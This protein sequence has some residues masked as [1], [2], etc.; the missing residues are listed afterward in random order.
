MNIGDLVWC[1]HDYYHLP[2][3]GIIVKVHSLNI[4]YNCHD[5]HYEIL[6][7]NEIYTLH[8]E[9][10]FNAEDDAIAY[11]MMQVKGYSKL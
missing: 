1:V 9:E 8:E 6:I 3:R 7:N 10:V 5:Y 11:Q 2:I 4:I